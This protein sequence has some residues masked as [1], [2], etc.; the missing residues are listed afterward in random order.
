MHVFN[1]SSHKSL[2]S[3]K[4]SFHAFK[5]AFTHTFENLHLYDWEEDQDCGLTTVWLL[6]KFVQKEDCV[7][8]HWIQCNMT[9]P[10]L[11]NLMWMLGGTTS[12]LISFAVTVLLFYQLSSDPGLVF[13]WSCASRLSDLIDVTLVCKNCYIPSDPKWSQVM[14]LLFLTLK[15]GYH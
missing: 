2:V 14:F 15:R 4:D 11:E 10:A 5:V 3:C 7:T 8:L 6:S 12:R 1:P 13:T 9:S